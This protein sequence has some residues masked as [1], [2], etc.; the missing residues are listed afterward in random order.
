MA[1]DE[2]EDVRVVGG[3]AGERADE[4]GVADAEDDEAHRHVAQHRHDGPD[5]VDALLGVSRVTIT[6]S[7]R[8]VVGPPDRDRAR[9]PGSRRR[10]ASRP[11]S[12]GA[13]RCREQASVAGS[14]RAVSIPLRMPMRSPARARSASSRPKP[15]AGVRISRAWLGDTATMRSARAMPPDSGFVPPHHS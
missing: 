10:A 7:G 2:R 6:A 3:E 4:R 5:Q 1:L 8:A 9:P 11:R 12:V 13:Q 15:P 14:Q